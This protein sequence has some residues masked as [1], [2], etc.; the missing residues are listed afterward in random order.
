M[1]RPPLSCRRAVQSLQPTPQ[2]IWISDDLLNLAVNQFFRNACPH[3]KRHGSHVPGPLEAR[4]RAAKRRMTVSANFYPQE[5]F[6]PPISL[7][8]LFGFRKASPP[9]WRYE[10][11]SLSHRDTPF[12]FPST[13]LNP[14]AHSS[15]TSPTI[16]TSPPLSCVPP[17]ASQSVPQSIVQSIPK[18]YA[19]AV[20]SNIES[21]KS[22]VEEAVANP[23]DGIVDCMACFEKFKLHMAQAVET[24]GTK[25]EDALISI[26]RSYRPTCSENWIYSVMV[27]KHMTELGLDPIP[28]FRKTSLFSIPPIYTVEHSEL[29]GYLETLSAR[30]PHRLHEFYSL[31]KRLATAA[32]EAE[33]S[34]SSSQDSDILLLVQQL[35]RS[36]HARK[37]NLQH[38]KMSLLH[39]L[40]SKVQHRRT[41]RFLEAV[42]THTPNL[43]P[44]IM[45]SIGMASGQPDLVHAFEQ[46]LSCI[47]REQLLSLSPLIIL[48]LAKTA[49]GK[50][51]PSSTDSERLSI[52]LRIMHS[53]DHKLASEATNMTLLDANLGQLTRHVFADQNRVQ[54]KLRTLLHAVL[55]KFSHENR[56]HETPHERLAKVVDASTNIPLQKGNQVK[57]GR[58]LADIISRLH[59]ESLPCTWFTSTVSTLLAEHAPLDSL[60]HFVTRLQTEGII[61]PELSMMNG[62]ITDKVRDL[63][64][65]PS[66]TER[67]RQIKA[68]RLSTCQVI[69]KVLGEITSSPVDIHDEAETLQMQ[70][71][72]QHLLE[73]AEADGDLPIP[74]RNLT[75]ALTQDQRTAII[76]Q[77]A[78][79]YSIDKAISQREAWRRIFY[80]YSYLA[81]YSL[82]IRPRFTNAIVR[83][84]L[85]RALEE[86][87]F[88]SAR[89]L[90]W[91]CR[92]VAD[93]EGEHVAKEIESDFWHWRGELVKHAKARFVEAGG[94]VRNKASIGTMKRLRLI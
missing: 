70:R 87:R 59:K 25:Q 19:N 69:L 49:E 21:A 24:L 6:P 92:V 74:Y 31:I 52:W 43:E 28:L 36:A 60:L 68:K 79:H 54:R 4:R 80:L 39:Q 14:S 90:I 61:M 77:L 10:P 56:L 40:A 37:P 83:V 62:I 94:N 38:G 12:D 73:R 75:T 5:N 30:L 22:R 89:R 71:Q 63:E 53:L 17:A 65:A 58:A 33:A 76:H 8:A 93:V 26:Y 47:P 7:A 18:D 66:A 81:R 64:Q 48:R 3:Q 85:T 27:V 91:V 72:F 15:D 55:Y 13:A 41:N 57:P 44:T 88:V 45:Y 50:E 42:V 23:Q 78:H 16:S 20:V 86:R 1:R 11:P 51:Q 84:S 46:V 34:S 2:H 82:P 35:W 32:L 9:A 67:D 29:L